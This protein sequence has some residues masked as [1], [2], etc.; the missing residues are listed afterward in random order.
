MSR[1]HPPAARSYD[2]LLKEGA[3]LDRQQE[4]LVAILRGLCATAIILAA[5]VAVV[6]VFN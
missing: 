6:N 3:R 1:K 2:D 4:I 5:W